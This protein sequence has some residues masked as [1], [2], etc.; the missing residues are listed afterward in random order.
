MLTASV[1]HGHDCNKPIKQHWGGILLKATVAATSIIN[2]SSFA[3]PAVCRSR[4]TRLDNG[5]SSCSIFNGGRLPT[6]RPLHE[7]PSTRKW[8]NHNI[9]TPFGLICMA[10]DKGGNQDK[11]DRLHTT[12]SQ[13]EY[14]DPSPSNIFRN[15]DDATKSPLPS[16]P[17]LGDMF[18]QKETTAQHP[19]WILSSSQIKKLKVVELRQ[20]CADRNLIKVS[21]LIVFSF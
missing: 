20:A 14:E 5:C 9:P 13:R 15:T 18:E 16:F 10:M 6:H 3:G 21:V 2:V 17:E 11:S 7:F 8:T 12:F 4:K 19:P 1:S